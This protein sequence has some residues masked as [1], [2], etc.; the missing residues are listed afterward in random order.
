VFDLLYSTSRLA[1]AVRFLKRGNR[2]VARA[3]VEGLL[4]GHRT[5]EGQVDR[6]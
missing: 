2:A 4:D 5:I 3:I 1:L 6:Y